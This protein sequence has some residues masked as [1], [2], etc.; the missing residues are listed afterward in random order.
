M[1]AYY[2]TLEVND[3]HAGRKRL[4]WDKEGATKVHSQCIEVIDGGEDV[5]VEF[6]SPCSGDMID[7]RSDSFDID[8]SA[9]CSV[10]MI[11]DIRQFGRDIG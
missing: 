2:K 3:Q 7:K 1:Y 9:V 4:T 10:E 5:V 11:Q 6:L 8:T